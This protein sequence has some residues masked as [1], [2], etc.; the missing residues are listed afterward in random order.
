MQVI[1]S[2]R[3]LEAFCK[4]AAGYDFVTVDTEFLRET[5]YWPKLCLIQAATP[6]RAVIIDPLADGI[7]LAPFAELLANSLVTKVFH[8]ARQDIEIF[9]K[10]FGAVPHPIFDTQIAASVCGH[11]DSV[12][13]DNLVRAVVGTQIDKSSRFTDWAARPLSEKQLTYALAD[14]THLRDIYAQLRDEI[15]KTRRSSWVEDEMAVLE[16]L[17]TY[18]VEPADAW[19]R[20]KLKVSKPRDL[21]AMQAIAAWREQRAQNNDQP[22]SRVLKDDAIYELAQQRPTSPEAFDKLRA[23]PRGFGKSSAGSDLIA[24]IKEVEARDKSQ[25]PVVPQRPRGP[26]PK[27]AIGDLLRVLLK[28]VADR[29][30]VATRIIANSEDIDAIVLDD[31][32]DVPALKGWRRKLFGEKALAIKHGRLALAATRKGIVEIEIEAD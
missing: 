6:D 24:V 32:A 20:L 27:G 9:V 17:S 22:R 15:K 19:K 4:D 14:V 31:D 30:G 12:S 25:L 26:S 10:L 13:Y 16:S 7:D 8:A 28:A 29:N 18:I 21:A 5:T 11:G 23:V 3:A 2:T 1:T